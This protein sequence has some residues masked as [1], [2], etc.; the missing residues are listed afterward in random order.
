M[1][2]IYTLA[3]AVLFTAASFAQSSTKVPVNVS[4]RATLDSKAKSFIA[5]KTLSNKKVSA[6]GPFDLDLDPIEE[7]MKQKQIDLT[8]ANPQEDIFITGLYQDST[9]MFSSPSSVRPV[10]DIFLGSVMDPRSSLLQASFEPIVSNDD[11]YTLDSLFILGSYMKTTTAT[12]TLFTYIVWG[13]STNTSV[14]T[15]MNSTSVW[16]APISGWRKSLI[17]PKVSG[18][19]GAAGNKV[20]AAAPTTNMQLVKYVLKPTDSVSAS[21]RVKFISIGF[22]PITIPAKNMVSAFYTFVPGAT[23]TVGACA[24]NLGGATPQDVNGFAAAIWSQASPAITSVND[25]QNYQVDNTS[26]TMGVSYDKNQRHAKYSATYNNNILGIPM[27]SPVM[28]YSIQ[29]NS[30][31]GINELEIDGSAILGQNTPNPFTAESSVAYQLNKEANSASFTVTDVTGR[32]IST[33]KV[34]SNVGKHTV[35]LASYSAGVYYYTLTVDGKS[36]TKK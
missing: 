3:S 14:F 2:K 23:N 20:K 12:D 27:S 33:E 11:S 13:D 18:A 22:S 5:N 36:A 15:K 19:V 6:A 30:T 34:A 10:D 1:K 28:Y 32:V 26:M 29:G 9:V 35:K 8:S 7:V 4:N 24:Y 16:V 21:G 17:G 31:V 25:Y